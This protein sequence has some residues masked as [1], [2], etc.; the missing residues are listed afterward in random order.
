MDHYC[1]EEEDVKTTDGKGNLYTNLTHHKDDFLP[2]HLKG[3]HLI[4]P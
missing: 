1:I 3:K 4:G 2:E